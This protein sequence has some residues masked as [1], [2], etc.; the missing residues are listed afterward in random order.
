MRAPLCSSREIVNALKRAGC[1]E[2]KTKGNGS[3]LAMVRVTEERKYVTVVVLGKKEVPRGT[4]KDI[5]EKAGLTVEE[6][7]EFLK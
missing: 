7:I 2:A 6:F 1:T 4:L 3:H 5:L